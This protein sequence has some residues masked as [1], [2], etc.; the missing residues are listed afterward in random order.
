MSMQFDGKSV[1]ITGGASG[2]G[3]VLVEMFASAGAR[4]FFTYRSSLERARELEELYEG[5]VIGV[6]ADA[7]DFETAQSVVQRACNECGKIDILINNAASAKHKA[8]LSLGIEDFRY[9]IENTLLPVF[10]Y[11]RAAAPQMVEQGNG[12]I[13]TIGS[14]NGERGREG[15]APYCAAKAG[16]VGLSKTIAKELGESG[17]RC[18]VVEP[19]YITTDGQ[20]NTSPLIQKLVLDECAIRRLTAPEEVGNLVMFLASDLARN[21]TGQVYRIDCGQ[22]I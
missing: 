17:V 8:F 5:K 19:G 20:A 16:V 22:Y 18:N 14:I 6:C 7:S 21:I 9:S 4:V 10:N 13:I 12:S 11:C 15:S 1:L 2:L 3:R